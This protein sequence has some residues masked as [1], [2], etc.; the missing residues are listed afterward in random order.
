MKTSLLLTVALLLAADAAPK[1]PS[2]KDLDLMQGDWQAVS[3]VVDGTTLP[4]DDAGAYFRT[5]KK[6]Q[7]TI[8]R[9]D[10]PI[11]KGTL[12]LDPTKSPKTF[13]ARI[14]GPGGKE[15]V[16]LGIYEIDKDNLKVCTAR[17][18][19]ERPKAFESPAGSELSLSVWVREKK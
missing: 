19:K 17:P 16:A 3:M 10:K 15:L 9:Y 11:S 4:P 5:V 18:G 14:A 6:D 7:Y 2:Q 12:R 1:D 13:D 8:F